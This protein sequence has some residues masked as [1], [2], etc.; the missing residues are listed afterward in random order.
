M[1]MKRVQNNNF[2]KTK[3]ILTPHNSIM[4]VNIFVVVVHRESIIDGLLHC[5]R[6]WKIVTFK[7]IL[8]VC[9]NRSNVSM[10]ISFLEVRG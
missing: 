10:N 8:A 1:F 7:S 6:F 5:C 3:A 9:S 4:S 2:S